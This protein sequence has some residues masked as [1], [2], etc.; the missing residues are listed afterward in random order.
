VTP[1]ELSRIAKAVADLLAREGNE[2][3]TA[4]D[5]AME[6]TEQVISSYEEIQAKAYNLIVLGHFRLDDDTSYVAAVGPL[7]SRAKARAKEV[8]ERF[9]WDYKT[10]KGTGQFVLVPLVRNPAEAW[11]DVRLSQLVEYEGGMGSITPGTEPSYEPMRFDLPEEVRARIAAMPD[12]DEPYYAT[13]DP[14]RMGLTCVCGLIE[15][16]EGRVTCPRHPEGRDSG[17]EHAGPGGSDQRS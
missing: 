9:A 8:G 4:E 3:T 13:G 14:Y 2:E 17:R 1:G 11:D 7:S 15:V 16:R 10:R 6:V 5:L 12:A